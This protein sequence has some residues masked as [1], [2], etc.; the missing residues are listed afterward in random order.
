MVQWSVYITVFALIMCRKVG[1]KKLCQ[2]LCWMLKA[3]I[4]VGF[5]LMQLL[6]YIHTICYKNIYCMCVLLESLCVKLYCT[7]IWC[8]IHILL[9]LQAGIYYDIHVTPQAPYSFVSFE[10][11]ME[12]VY[13]TMYVYNYKMSKL[14]SQNQYHPLVFWYR[15]CL[16]WWTQIVNINLLD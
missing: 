15:V 14:Y 9:L 16:I 11:N 2:M 1:L 10:T 3:L 12:E 7:V 5:Q 6:R 8:V 4:L 13:N